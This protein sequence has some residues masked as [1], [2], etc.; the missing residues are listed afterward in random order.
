M[1]KFI[2]NFLF[3][4]G[5]VSTWAWSWSGS[6]ILGFDW[7]F[8]IFSRAQL[9]LA[10]FGDSPTKSHPQRGCHTLAIREA[11]GSYSHTSFCRIPRRPT[12][13]KQSKGKGPGEVR[14]SPFLTRILDYIFQ[15]LLQLIQLLCKLNIWVWPIERKSSFTTTTFCLCCVSGLEP[16]LELWWKGK[17][18]LK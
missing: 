1:Q 18:W 14:F 8:L 9:A 5:A 10:W 7:A 4:S 15:K 16:G 3:I 6:W 11:A 13:A 12:G 2:L 17:L